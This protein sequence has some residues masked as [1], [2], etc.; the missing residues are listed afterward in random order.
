MY[1]WCKHVTQLMQQHAVN[2]M[3]SQ[4]ETETQQ[5]M[6]PSWTPVGTR[7]LWHAVDGLWCQNRRDPRRRRNVV[8]KWT[9]T[10]MWHDNI[11]GDLWQSAVSLWC[12]TSVGHIIRNTCVT[13]NL[14]FDI[15][16]LR[17]LIL[18]KQDTI[19]F[20]MFQGSTSSD[21]SSPA[22]IIINTSIFL[23]YAVLPAQSAA[24][25]IRSPRPRYSSFHD[26]VMYL[27]SL[28]VVNMLGN[29]LL[30]PLNVCWFVS[31]SIC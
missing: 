4:W 30:P 28:T 23:G 7:P 1:L 22:S 24:D 6:F 9:S 14:H 11:P 15:L 13:F 8:V 10:A 12:D 29:W 27:S 26:H 18:I 21:V 25:V 20:L 19:L 3:F 2:N 31:F 16:H 17:N 5:T